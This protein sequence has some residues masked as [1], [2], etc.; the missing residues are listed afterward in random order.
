[1]KHIEVKDKDTTKKG[2]IAVKSSSTKAPQRT[3][4]RLMWKGKLVK[5][6]SVQK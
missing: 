1:M 6:E 3:C 5:Q 2:S 4:K